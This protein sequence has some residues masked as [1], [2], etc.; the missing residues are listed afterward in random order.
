MREFNFSISQRSSRLG[1]EISDIGECRLLFVGKVPIQTFQA[2][3]AAIDH[4]HRVLFGA[5]FIHRRHTRSS[6]IGYEPI[7]FPETL[8][9]S[10]VMNTDDAAN[11]RMKPLKSTIADSCHSR[12]EWTSSQRNLFKRLILLT[13]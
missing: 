3:F 4:L 7:M 9:Q 5:E 11:V 1:D 2:R 8:S 6:S 12:I 10:T 13:D